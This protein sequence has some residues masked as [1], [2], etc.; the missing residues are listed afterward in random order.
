M[1]KKS[2]IL[3]LFCLALVCGISF[4]SAEDVNQTTNAT[5]IVDEGSFATIQTAVNQANANDVIYLNNS[6]YQSTGDSIKINKDITIDGSSATESGVSTLDGKNL[7]TIINVVGKY[8]LTLQNI[9]FINSNGPAV[10]SNYEGQVNII[11]CS[12]INN[13][14]TRGAGIYATNAYV[15]NCIFINNTASY[16][17]GGAIF[18]PNLNT[19][20]I[21]ANSYFE[22]NT[23]VNRGGAIFSNTA[24]VINSTFKNNHVSHQGEEA[25]YGGA[26]GLTSI[27]GESKIIN[28]T[29]ENN[30]C[31]VSG[32]AVFSQGKLS[33]TGS[34]FTNNSAP[35]GGAVY[36][37]TNL[38][39]NNSIFKGNNATLGGAL[40]GEGTFV[41]NNSTFIENN[42]THGGAINNGEVLQTGTTTITNSNFENNT[43]DAFYIA[44]G[45]TATVSNSNFTNNDINNYGTLT[46]KNNNVVTPNAGIYNYATITVAKLII[47][48]NSTVTANLNDDVTITG[49]LVDDNGNRIIQDGVTFDINKTSIATTHDE[50]GVYSANYQIKNYGITPVSGDATNINNLNVENG[51]ILVKTPTEIT[52]TVSNITYGESAVIT[53]N[54]TPQT[55]GN[56]TITVNN[57]E[58]NVTLTHSAATIRVEGLNASSYPVT[59]T[60]N[61]DSLYT[62]STNSTTFN[63]AKKDT[64]LIVEIADVVYGNGF[65]INAELSDKINGTV[66]VNVNGTDYQIPTTNGVGSLPVNKILNEGNYTV[67]GKF[68]GNE[69]Y[70]PA[71]ATSQFHVL[72]TNTLINVQASNIV[73]GQTATI[74][75]NVT[76]GAT[77]NVTFYVNNKNYTRDL[78]NNGIATLELPNL[79]ATIYPVVVVYNGDTNHDRSGNSTHFTVYKAASQLN[80]TISNLTYG[81]NNIIT[82]NLSDK[83]NGT[84]N[85]AIDHRT[86]NIT[87]TNGIGTI[88]I[89]DIL[90]AENYTATATFKGNNN[91][92]TTT[93]TTEFNVEK[94]NTTL[95]V[96][97]DNITYGD[98]FTVNV[99]LSDNLNGNVKVT[100]NNENYTIAVTNGE[101]SK[102]INTPLNA[103]NY[104]VTATYNGNNNYN[105]S[106]NTTQFSVNKANSAL[107]ITINNITYGQ[108]PT[109][110]VILSNNVTG[111]VNVTV[112][113]NVYPVSV[114]N[115]KGIITIPE[116]LKANNYTATADYAGNENY[117]SAKFATEFNVAKAN[118]PLNV[119]I[120][121][122]TYGEYPTVNVTLP[123]EISGEVNVTVNRNL[124]PVNVE[125]GKGS[126]TI[127]ELYNG[128]NNYNSAKNITEF[129]INPIATIVTVNVDNIKYG[130]S[131]KGSIILTDINNKPINGTVLVAINNKTFEVKVLN[132]NGNF[133]I[134]NLNPGNYTIIAEFRG[135]NN[136]NPSINATIITVNPVKPDENQTTNTTT[137]NNT[138]SETTTINAN[139]N[140]TI[141]NENQTITST[142]NNPKTGNPIALLLALLMLPLRR[143]KQ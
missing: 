97:I 70:N 109:V 87:T 102:T 44:A 133:T 10:F 71:T 74:K 47:L 136:Y 95:E 43:D 139:N 129:K 15:D 30:T 132:G 99:K 142:N 29:F 78:D 8:T 80:I 100:I 41:I 1:V 110:D 40:Y 33:I 42:A 125:N 19:N 63:V 113:G 96:S 49:V 143:K 53:V 64:S 120:N 85:V 72:V 128:N 37:M 138:T 46:L 89:P 126:I 51:E 5:P 22:N 20:V 68:D 122:V 55:T 94:Q 124:Y 57:R 106:T 61:G 101:S 13:T 27:G 3:L 117:N 50:N 112:N 134:A 45:T 103:K 104:T 31:F 14:A 7:N 25:T 119:E 17:V 82:V 16:D 105:P 69:N 18:G 140:T 77:G 123:A 6:D 81:E 2:S 79:N 118:S 116:L 52:I 84:V 98:N 35:N 88:E 26:I 21:V 67:T 23:A 11:N 48:D 83:I 58:Y 24:T 32:G 66:T 38:N 56:V 141:D 121:N 114:V 28:S 34:N 127:P 93:A 92:N 75:T 9:N 135:T 39:V 137:N 36:G 115:G 73:Y 65:T 54:V 108:Y 107:T 4:V 90:D 12:F 131:V 91:Y 86:Y 130:E 59:A 60:Y 76:P 62:T 111:V